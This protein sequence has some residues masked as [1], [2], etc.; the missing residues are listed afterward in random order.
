MG[1]QELLHALE[2]EVARQIRELQAETAHARQRLIDETRRQLAAKR[3]EILER[4][5]RRLDEEAGRTLSQAR[6]ERERAVLTEMRHLLAELRREAE[7]RLSALGGTALLAGLV[8]ELIPECGEGPL[9]FRVG[10]GCEEDLRNHLLAHHA[11]I[12]SRARIVGSKE[13]RGGVKASLGGR[14]LLDNTLPARIEK[15]WQALEG[16]VAVLLFGEGHG[17][18]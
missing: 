12:M 18:L 6:L 10:E 5:R 11:E 14:Q 9:E 4:E 16:E 15:A 3:E 2:D 1:Y 7:D 17:G 13:I 8:D